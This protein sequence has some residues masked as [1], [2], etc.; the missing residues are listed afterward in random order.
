MKVLK[1]SQVVRLKQ[2]EHVVSEKNIL[3]TVKKLHGPGGHPFIVNLLNSYQDHRCLF[4]L[5]EYISG[6]EIF[7]HL[8]R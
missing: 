3:A 5:E 1:K 8:R 7:S 2:V 6:G 4:M